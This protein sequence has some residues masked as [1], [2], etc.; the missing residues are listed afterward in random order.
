[1]VEQ[2][3]A[4]PSTPLRQL[5]VMGNDERQRLLLGWNDTAVVV[6]DISLPELVARWAAATPD[7]PAVLFE[8]TTVSYLQLHERSVRQARQLLASGVGPG[9][10][11]AVALPRSEE[12][13]IALLAIM[14]T[15]AAYLPIDLDSPIERQALVL[16][17]ASPIALIAKPQMQARFARGGFSLLQPEHPDAP[18]SRTAQE[19]D[20][21]APEGTAYVLYTSGSTGRPKGVE[22]THRNLCNFLQGMQR[23]LMLTASDRFLAVTTVIFDIAALELY[24]PLTVGACVVMASNKS[25]HHPPVLA[26]LIQKSGV[27]HVQATPSLWRILLASSETRLDDVHAM[28]GGE[29]LS[30]DLAA[31]LKSMAARVTQFY[32]PTETTIWSTAYELGEIGANPPPIGRPILNTQIYVL[33]EDRQPVLTGAIGELYIGG[34][35]VAKGYLHRPKLTEERFLANPFADDGSRMYRT[36]DLVRWSDDGLLEFI[37]RADDQVKING[38]RVEL[39]EIESLLLQHNKVAEAAVA[40]HRDGDGTISL[41]GY[42]VVSNGALVDIDMLRVF[43]ADRLPHYMMPANFMVLDAMPLTPNGKLDRKA[44]PMPQ[45]TSRNVYA[46]PITPTEKKLAELWQQILGVERVGLHDNFFELGGDSLNV[47]EMVAQFSAHFEIELPLGSLFEAPTIADLAVLVER[48][49]SA[50]ID[51]LAV[52]LPLRIVAKATRRPLFCIHPMT[53]VSLGFS[54]L[55]RHLDPTMQVYGLQSRGLNGG[56]I[57]PASIEEIATDYLHQIRRIQPEGPYRLIG[58]SLGG[59]IGHSIAEQMQ[60]Q[61]LQ[62]ELLAMLDSSLF[63]SGEF[64][65]PCTEADEVRVALSFLDIHLVLENTPQTLKQLGE[66][67]LHP[68]NAHSIPQT[69]GIM[70]LAREIK[71]SNPEFNKHLSAVMFNN[72]KLARQYVPRK[73]DLDLLYFHATEFTGDVDGILDRSPSAWRPFIGRKIEVYKL[74]CHHE[75]VL[76]PVP[77]AQIGSTLRQRI[78]ILDGQWV[79][80]TS[81]A[82]GRVA[83]AIT[84]VYV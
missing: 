62:V 49:S 70:K 5:D 35:G 60:A 8:D 61:N 37:G 82:I 71:K 38:H 78:S 4:N 12:L 16:E 79:P 3:L 67:L 74:A 54:G 19:P 13:L 14:R 63:T 31:R 50:D 84:A 34:A 23:Q 75:A 59:L 30:A 39:G 20:L 57:L 45:R 26:R 18:L 42:V 44:L 81:P 21:S 33:D 69:Q 58:R 72:L 9:D 83:G 43:L 64:S 7:A 32:G 66:F 17:D 27:T 15:G 41:A 51:P 10:I 53:G 2:V 46:D 65:R 68:D 56:A 40:A 24:L 77:A 76:D 22:I 73:V 48:L 80:E 11:V 25:V 6:S 36:G 28:V 29:A 52:M 47:A 55:L 1:L